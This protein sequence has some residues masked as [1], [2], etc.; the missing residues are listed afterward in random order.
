MCKFGVD[1]KTPT[2][3]SLVNPNKNVLNVQ[4]QSFFFLETIP[5]QC[6]LLALD[7]IFFNNNIAGCFCFLLNVADEILSSRHTICAYL[8]N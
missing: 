7:G 1:C 2:R 8:F 3:R 4:D 5:V 6:R